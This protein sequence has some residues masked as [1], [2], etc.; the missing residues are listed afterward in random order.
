M[1]GT[2]PAKQVSLSN[3]SEGI[4]AIDMFPNIE[5]H[6]MDFQ[7]ALHSR[8]VRSKVNYLI[9]QEIGDQYGPFNLA[10]LP[11]GAYAPRSLMSSVHSAPE[12]AV[13]MHVDLRSKKSIGVHWGTFI[14]V[15]PLS[16]KATD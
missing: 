9:S 7:N 2:T 3:I 5:H 4:P 15:S 12:D 1:Q 11:V 6:L 14:L 10:A 13:D 8:S 16:N